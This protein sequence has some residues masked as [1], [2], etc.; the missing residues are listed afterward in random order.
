[1]KKEPYQGKTVVQSADGM[2]EMDITKRPFIP[3][4]SFDVLDK[5]LAK[6]QDRRC[7]ILSG[8]RQRDVSADTYDTRRSTVQKVQTS[9]F[10][11]P[12]VGGTG[13]EGV[14]FFYCS[15]K[16]P[17]FGVAKVIFCDANDLGNVILDYAGKYGMTQHGIA[18]TISTK[19]E[20]AQIVQALESVEW[21]SFL[22]SVTYGGFQISPK[23][24]KYFR[25]D[26]WKEFV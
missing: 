19:E 1:M 9:K 18:I 22:K 13:K 21:N 12:L 6:G 15:V 23:M 3:N 24:F 14:N 7:E 26:F 8:Q 2:V 10:K 11:Y 25:A 20:G 17:Y 5:I 16:G 4:G